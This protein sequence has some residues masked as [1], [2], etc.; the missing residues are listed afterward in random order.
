[1]AFCQTQVECIL[2]SSEEVDT[3]LSTLKE[4][5][6]SIDSVQLGDW[7]NTLTIHDLEQNSN[8]IKWN[9]SGCGWYKVLLEKLAQRFPKS[10]FAQI[11][12]PIDTT[13]YGNWGIDIYFDGQEQIS[14][15]LYPEDLTEDPEE[16]GFVIP[17]YDLTNPEIYPNL[18]R[19]LNLAMDEGFKLHKAADYN[20]NKNDLPCDPEVEIITFNT[21]YNISSFI[22]EHYDINSDYLYELRFK[23]EIEFRFLSIL[24]AEQ[25]EGED[26]D[27]VV[28]AFLRY[29]GKEW[30]I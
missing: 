25:C 10:R 22:E 12:L 29:E 7:W 19:V 18:S 9:S 1:M 23:A 5:L 17:E 20:F 3:F 27:F 28:S 14:T 8:R 13:N 26:F 6:T 2:N 30:S 24:K 4:L 16:V 15:E 21:L 11:W